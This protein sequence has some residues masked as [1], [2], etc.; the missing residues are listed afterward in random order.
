MDRGSFSLFVA[1]L[2]GLEPILAQEC[3][4][5]GM[6]PVGPVVSGE[7]GVAGSGTAA[8]VCALNVRLG[9]ASHVLLRVSEFHAVH[10]AELRRKTAS[11]GWADWLGPSAPFT[12]AATARRSRLYH[13]GAI[14]ERVADAIAEVVG[15]GPADSEGDAAADA[16]PVVARLLED[17]CTLSIDTSGRPLHEQG[18]RLET[19]KA[20]LREDLAGALL[21]ASGW[22]P[23][24]PFVDPFCGSGTLPILAARRA[25]GIPPGASRTFAGELLPFLPGELWQFARSPGAPAPSAPILGSDRNAGAIAIAS[26]NAARAGVAD[27][28]EFAV[29]AV[30]NAPGFA[31]DTASGAVV[32]NPPFGRR[33]GGADLGPLYQSLGQRLDTLPP[34]WRVALLAADR[35]LALRTGQRL[36]T[37]FLTTHGGLR[38][39]ALTRPG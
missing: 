21:L 29:A 12:V 4:A 32:T 18:W 14:R 20:P 28:V 36:G 37:A 39:R 5:A 13:S 33:V 25:R 22:E 15:R 19:A 27:H 6:S 34:G 26:R 30:S 31:L 3:E 1:C 2:P 23:G 35:R 17:R 16:V 38:V 11:A 24:S 9:T 7:G 10:F 8:T